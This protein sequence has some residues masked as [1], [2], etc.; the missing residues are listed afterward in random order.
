MTPG[1]S[2]H[3]DLVVFDVN[4]TLSDLSLM[5]ER[6]TDVGL[7]APAARAW[8]A[9]VLRDGFALTVT[10]DRTRFAELAADG[11]RPL[12]TGRSDATSAA[13]HVLAG[14][15]ALPLH[16]DVADGV[17]ALRAAG[18]RLAT[19]SNGSVSVAEGL[20]DRA[21]LRSSFEA[22]LSVED[23]SAWKPHRTAYGHALSVCGV[24]AERA[25][26]VAVHPW[27]IH[28][29]AAVGMRTAWISREG[30]P[31]PRSFVPPDYTVGTV[32]GLVDHLSAA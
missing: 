22:V 6:F 19:L 17:R 18:L 26:L 2:R 27:D 4:E 1:A 23:A 16:P 5:G 8:F 20:L 12:L 30:A 3:A 29:A 9:G 14:F 28:G 11:L 10:G 32:G 13:A 31:Y 21:G 24:P 25:V 15:S 7:P